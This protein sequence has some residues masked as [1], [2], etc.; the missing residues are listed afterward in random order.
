ML[1][2]ALKKMAKDWFL[3]GMISAVVLATLFP[4]I[5]M[6]GGTLHADALV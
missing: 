4:E 2:K 6:T 3:T 5:G 1:T